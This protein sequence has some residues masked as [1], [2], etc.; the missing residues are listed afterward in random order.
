MPAWLQDAAT[1]DSSK[2]LRKIKLCR[3]ADLWSSWESWQC[4]AILLLAVTLLRAWT[5]S[6]QMAAATTVKYL[7]L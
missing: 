2:Q 5:A 3:L 1:A 6:R 7:I 4:S